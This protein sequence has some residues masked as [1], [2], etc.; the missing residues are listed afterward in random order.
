VIFPNP[1][2]GG[3]ISVRTNISDGAVYTVEVFND[4]GMLVRHVS[5]STP[6]VLVRFSPGLLPGIYVAKVSSRGNSATRAF[7]VRR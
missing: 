5:A 7:L 1:M 4:Q 2:D 3:A 6:E